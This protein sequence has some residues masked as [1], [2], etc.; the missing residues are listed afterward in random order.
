MKTVCDK[1]CCAGCMACVEICSKHAISIRDYINAYNAIIDESKC[2]DCGACH[3]MCQ[4]NHQAK[5]RQPIYWKQGWA[6]QEAIRT[7]SS[8]GGAATAIEEAF[9]IAGGSVCSC[10][11][12]GG[13]FG[14]AFADNMEEVRHFC[15]SKY[16]KSNPEGVYSEIKNR[17]QNGQ[18]LLFVGLPCQ[19]SAVLNYL[20]DKLSEKL[21][22]VDLIC[23]GAPSPRL[24]DIFLSQY[25]LSLNNLKKIKFRE[26]N[27]FQLKND[28]RY[29]G[30]AGVLDKYTIAFL[31][32][33]SYTE[34]CYNCKYAKLERVA[35]V[36]LGDSWGSDLDK[37]IQKKG[38][39]LILCQSEKG[40]ELI[41]RADIELRDVDLEVAVAHN[42]Q[43]KYPS[44]MPEKRRFFFKEIEKD[45]SFNK[46]TW[47]IYPKQCFKQL[48]KS[49]L[50]KAKIIRGGQIANYGLIVSV[51]GNE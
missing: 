46:L 34:N 38:L 30:I 9:I 25:G 32:S 8:S 43:L 18:K 45:T 5:A 36:T 1:D 27:K 35:D 40:M 2:I 42:H 15:G 48:V 7:A 49:V 13:K 14:F 41:E 19:V 21:Y 3:R 29:V 16:V 44:V 12:V 4:A 51:K 33:I 50:I 20:G 11:F 24:L 28:E 17:L 23:H 31:N 47:E 10:V 22:T 6:K 39:S 37:E 26:N